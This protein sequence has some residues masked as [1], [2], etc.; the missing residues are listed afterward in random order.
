M[1]NYK[2]TVIVDGGHQRG[3]ETTTISH[4]EKLSVYSAA[5]EPIIL[6]KAAAAMGL[7]ISKVSTPGGSY[8][9][10]EI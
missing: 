1:P 7:D 5:D 2:V 8:W 4:G 10:E 9:F 6:R 3:P